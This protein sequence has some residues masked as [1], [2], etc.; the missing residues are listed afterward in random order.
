MEFK[1][2]YLSAQAVRGQEENMGKKAVFRGMLGFPL[3]I[4]IGYV[5][6]IFISLIWGRGYYSPCVPQLIDEMGSE[7]RAV[8]L[9]A[10]L[11]GILGVAFAAGSVI[12]EME[13][14]SIAK[15]TG[16]YFLV[17]VLAMIPVAYITNWMEHTLAGFISYIAIFAAIFVIIWV[18]QY[19]IWKSKVRQ[20]NRKVQ[21]KE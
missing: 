5:I 11:S 2:D 6:T 12:W 10:V 4:A 8:V 1:N 19:L 14:W 13:Q 3:G 9:Q 20:M 16:I 7:I 17:S 18:V 21:R 15:Q